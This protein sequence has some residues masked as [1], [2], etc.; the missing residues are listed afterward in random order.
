MNMEKYPQQEYRDELADKLKEI[1]NSDPENPQVAKAKAVGYL[2]AKKETGEYEESKKFKIA[3]F[4]ESME[5]PDLEKS[6][7]DFFDSEGGKKLEQLGYT[8][9][10]NYILLYPDKSVH[11]NPRLLL[12]KRPTIMIQIESLKGKNE[13][14]FV[15]DFLSVENYIPEYLQSHLI[16]PKFTYPQESSKRDIKNDPKW[17]LGDNW[18]TRNKKIGSREL[19]DRISYHV[20]PER[21]SLV[22]RKE[23][24]LYVYVDK[25]ENFDEDR[26]DLKELEGHWTT[27]YSLETLEKRGTRPQI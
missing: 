26:G 18:D 24:Y 15:K 4:K 2:E 17:L 13:R 5:I 7:S 10:G 1:R 23:D 12:E 6:L 14:D 8:W 11:S 16:F 25:S 20:A 22:S 19:N 9:N 3:D 27:D 21:P